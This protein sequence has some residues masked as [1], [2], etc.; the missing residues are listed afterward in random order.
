VITLARDGMRNDLERIWR[1]C[2]PS[3]SLEY[4]KFF[5]DNRYNPNKCIVYVDEEVGR[6]VAMIHLFDANI[7]EDYDIVPVHYLYAAATRPDHQ[8]RGYMGKLLRAAQQF[9]KARG[10]RYTVL[11]PGSYSL[12]KFYEKHKYYRCFKNRVINMSRGEMEIISDWKSHR[13]EGKNVT[14]KFTDKEIFTIRRECLIDREGYISWSYQ[15]VSYAMRVHEVSGGSVL[16]VITN[17]DADYAFCEQEEETVRISEFVG[18]EGNSKKLVRV[19]LDKYPSAERF[20]IRV[21]TSNV[22]FS[23]YGD[24]EVSAMIRS[25]EDRQPTALLTLTENHF[26]YMG[27]PLD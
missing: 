3:D 22:F 26:P 20:S 13:G 7:T 10:V 5:F 25:A 8:G 16:A 4:V 27:L 14:S 2:F 17:T 6:P 11:A 12:M 1:L 23:A 19:I 24:V 9:A 21:P 18:T 15:A